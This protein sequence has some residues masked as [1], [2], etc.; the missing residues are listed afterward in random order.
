[1]YSTCTGKVGRC[2]VGDMWHH[3]QCSTYA[4][5]AGIAVLVIMRH[6]SSKCIHDTIRVSPDMITE[7]G[8]WEDQDSCT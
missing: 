5:P 6:G 7:Y 8:L 2:E 3:V 1:M 4:M